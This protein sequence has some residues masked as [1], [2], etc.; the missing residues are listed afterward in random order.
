MS[1][2]TPP[3]TVPA[4]SSQQ[5]WW[6]WLAAA[7]LSSVVVLLLVA[8]SYRGSD[9]NLD[10]FGSLPIQNG[11]RVKPFDSL[12]RTSLMIITT[13]TVYTDERGRSRPV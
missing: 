7:I 12:A 6:T 10:A 8:S 2:V 5:P 11:G 13:R 9:F 3:A 4:A 1:Q